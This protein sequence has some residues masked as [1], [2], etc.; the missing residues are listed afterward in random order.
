VPAELVLRQT[1][2][3]LTP[4]ERRVETVGAW[5]DFLAAGSAAGT[6]EILRP[7]GVRVHVAFRAEA[8]CP[9]PGIHASVLSLAD[10]PRDPRSV[11]D[12]VAEA[13]PASVAVA[14]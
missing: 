4:P 9:R 3:D 11:R 1:L 5:A 8:D 7:D 14:A 13:F 10:A 2:A 12:L 6:F